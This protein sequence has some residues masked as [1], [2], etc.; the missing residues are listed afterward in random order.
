MKE[1]TKTTK[2]TDFPLNKGLLTGKALT[3]CHQMSD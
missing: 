1:S 2:V 3:Q